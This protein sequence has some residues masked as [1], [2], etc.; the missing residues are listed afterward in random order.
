ML[1]DMVSGDACHSVTVYIKITEMMALAY[2][3]ALKQGTAFPRDL[4][5]LLIGTENT[6]K[7]SLIS[8]FLGEQFVENQ[9]A[10]DGAEM[11]ICKVYAKGWKR[12]TQSDKIS[13]LY[14]QFIHTIQKKTD[15]VL[16]TKLQLTCGTPPKH[17]LI[18]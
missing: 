6:G 18:A 4:A 12:I 5:V 8:T 14:G 17:K 11:Q 10:T 2:Q 13:H 1:S 3:L 15:E 9:S 16:A 7:T